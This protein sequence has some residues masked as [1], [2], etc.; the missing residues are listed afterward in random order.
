MKKTPNKQ[1]TQMNYWNKFCWELIQ[2]CL[3]FS[4]PTL[5]HLRYI[6]CVPKAP[7]REV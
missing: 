7:V 3:S 1:I 2:H 6:H 4:T 5:Y